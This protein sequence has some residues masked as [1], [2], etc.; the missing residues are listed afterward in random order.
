MY[1]YCIYILYKSFL[2]THTHTQK[3]YKKEKFFS[4]PS[5]NSYVYL[6]ST[7]FNLD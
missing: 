2:H 6:A 4:T 3:V 1:K 7:N 5:I